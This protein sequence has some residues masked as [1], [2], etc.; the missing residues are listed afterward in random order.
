MAESIRPVL[1][2]GENPAVTLYILGAEQIAAV[3]SYWNCTYSAHGAGQALVIWL[4]EPRHAALGAVYTD[5]APLARMLVDT[6]TRHFPEFQGIPVA[7]LPHIPA[8][9]R[10]ESDGRDRY[11]AHCSAPQAEIRVEW[12]GVLDQKLIRWPG[13][14][15]G[16]RAYDLSTVICPCRDAAILLGGA[17]ISGEVRV[18]ESG[19]WPSSSAFLAFAET[20][21]GPSQGEV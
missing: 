20:W 18:G 4:A 11:A 14:P 8:Q 19:G 13:F 6:L 1:L 7:D 12:S 10:R 5:N 15:A 21:V 17:P 2:C 9:L 3:A 16:P